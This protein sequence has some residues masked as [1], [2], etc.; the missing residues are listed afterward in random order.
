M[1]AAGLAFYAATSAETVLR[2]SLVPDEAPF[3]LRSKFIPLSKYLE[4]KI[5][6][7]IEFRP[8]SDANALIDALAAN[9]LD[10]AWFSGF[11]F[12]RARSRSDNQVIPIV[13]RAEDT[14]TRSVFITARNDITKLE[15]L[16]GKVFSFGEKSSTSGHLMPRFFLR[17]AYM[18]P[19][20]QMEHLIYADSNM[21]VVTAVAGGMADAGVLNKAIWERMLANGEVN[22]K[23]LHVFHTT[24]AYHDYNWTVHV[25]MDSNLRQR[26]TDAFL[27]MDQRIGIDKEILAMQR[28][29]RFISTTPKNY[30]P[31]ESVARSSGMLK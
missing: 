28:A 17:T 21:G 23:L 7:K 8:S 16:A 31:I 27:S 19:D 9:K 26:L 18:G 3:V 14:Q 4:K 2:V 15:D 22:S 1:I 10:M 6:M 25:D 5:G 24:P 30:S 13:Q 12:V 29:S 11:D 20:I